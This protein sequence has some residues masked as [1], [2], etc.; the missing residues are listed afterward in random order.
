MRA[1]FFSVCTSED[2]PGEA[3]RPPGPQPDANRVPK[4]AR[5]A[6]VT[7]DPISVPL[8]SREST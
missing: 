1:V 2:Y 6:R 4:F 7:F 3:P 8:P 5:S